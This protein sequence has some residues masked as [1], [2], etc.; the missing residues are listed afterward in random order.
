MAIYS[1]LKSGS[2]YIQTKSV[3][4]FVCKLWLLIPTQK[5]LHHFL[6][7]EGPQNIYMS[8]E[9]QY[10]LN[11]YTI[12]KMLYKLNEFVLVVHS[13][14]NTCYVQSMTKVVIFSSVWG[15]GPIVSYKWR[16]VVNKFKLSINL[17]P[18]NTVSVARR[19]LSLWW[20]LSTK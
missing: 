18:I 14:C 15:I 6:G 11:E 17:L 5:F 13:E 8:V 4:Y 12:L 20:S 16:L 9:S 3:Q 1:N 10:W 7:S 19:T 2:K